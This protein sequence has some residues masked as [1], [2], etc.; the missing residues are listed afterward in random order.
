MWTGSAASWVDLNPP[1]ISHSTCSGVGDGQQVGTAVVNGSFHA[2]LWT[3]TANSW[4]DLHPVG[5][6]D[7]V[8][9]AVDGGLQVGNTVSNFPFNYASLWYGT[10][11]SHIDLHSFLPAQS[12]GSDA[13]D[14]WQNGSFTYIVGGYHNPATNGDEAVM[15]ISRMIVATSFSPVR[16]IV[17]GG[18]LASL[19]NSDNNKLLIRPGVVFATGDPP[20]QIRV[21]ATA[22]AALPN[23][24][25]FSVETS[26]S[27]GNAQ[28]R[29]WLW[30][31]VIG[32]YE[33]VD[34]RLATL[35][36]DVTHVTIRTNSSRFIQP[37][38]LALRA[39]VTYRAVG[40]A[41][42]YPWSARIDKIWWT[43]P[44]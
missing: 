34:T 8:A 24:I 39:L 30:N 37:G 42:S 18:N 11:G 33:L 43:F 13:Y 12:Y 27:F 35:T 20:V 7:S 26:A 44:G 3:G 19:Q 41:F 29:I 9:H 36:D 14:I 4:I 6:Q 21:D 5:A 15:W 38:T 23:G 31:Y 28:Q 1:G 40:P 25:A 22:P 2:S 32:N 10:A 16:G 17:T